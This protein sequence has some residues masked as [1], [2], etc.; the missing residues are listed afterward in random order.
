MKRT[1]A[2]CLA[3][4]LV[5]GFTV[6]TATAMTVAEEMGWY[7]YAVNPY[8]SYGETSDGGGRTCGGASKTVCGQVSKETCVEWERFGNVPIPV[9]RIKVINT[10]Y[11][12]F[13]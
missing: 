10:D 6:Q 11:K 4:M 8:E 3:L 12:F 9:C 5:A 13:V 7:D 2:Q 1:I